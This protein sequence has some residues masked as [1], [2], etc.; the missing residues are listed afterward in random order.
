MP[1]CCLRPFSRDIVDKNVPTYK[2]IEKKSLYFNSEVFSLKKH[3]S[4]LCESIFLPK[5]LNFKQ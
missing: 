4:K 1:G 3:R 5:L 2:Q